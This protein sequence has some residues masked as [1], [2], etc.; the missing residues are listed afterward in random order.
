MEVWDLDLSSYDS[1]L[2]FGK[3]VCTE[4]QRLDSFIA[5]AGMEIQTFQM[6]ENTEK[7]L[8][9]NVVSCFMSAIACLSLLRKTSKDFDVQT[10]VTFCGSMYHIFGP[11]DELD[12]GLSDDAD[13]FNALS[14]FTRTAAASIQL[15][16]CEP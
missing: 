3:R 5:N 15:S 13:M 6:A 14:D 1:V 9:I 11:D 16:R 4:L 12:A 2:A 8:T 7:H 10:T